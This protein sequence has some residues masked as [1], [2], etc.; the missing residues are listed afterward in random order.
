MFPSLPQT[1]AETL[2]ITSTLTHTRQGRPRHLTVGRAETIVGA[3]FPDTVDVERCYLSCRASVRAWDG[4]R[5]FSG[6]RYVLLSTFGPLGDLG[7]FLGSRAVTSA[8][9]N[10]APR[11]ST[12]YNEHDGCQGVD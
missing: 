3:S 12:A 2:E 7:P 1:K 11:G 9:L 4:R 5:K 6:S 10:P 8:E